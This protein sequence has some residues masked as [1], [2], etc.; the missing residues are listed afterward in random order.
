MITLRG[1]YPSVCR[2]GGIALEVGLLYRRAMLTRGPRLEQDFQA[3]FPCQRGL[4]VLAYSL[5]HFLR[6]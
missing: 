5:Q 2:G 1:S 6:Y 3:T 4:L